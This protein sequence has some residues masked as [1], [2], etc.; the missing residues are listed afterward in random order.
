MHVYVYECLTYVVRL[1]TPVDIS[2]AKLRL[3]MCVK[4]VVVVRDVKAAAVVAVLVRGLKASGVRLR[5][6]LA[7]SARER[8]VRVDMWKYTV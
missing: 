5:A 2:E 8:I 3:E 4:G 6:E 7:K 1:W